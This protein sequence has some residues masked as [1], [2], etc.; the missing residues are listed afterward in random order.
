[1]PAHSLNLSLSCWKKH[2]SRSLRQ[3][4]LEA[5]GCIAST[6]GK[7]RVLNAGAQSMFST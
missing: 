2:G 7:H 3:R 4:E 6:L 5:A 1:M